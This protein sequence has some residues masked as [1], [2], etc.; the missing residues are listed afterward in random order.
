MVK[1]LQKNPLSPFTDWE[2]VACHSSQI[3]SCQHK[4]SRLQVHQRAANSW[5][6]NYT[7][8]LTWSQTSPPALPTGVITWSKSVT[9]AH[10]AVTEGSRDTS[11]PPKNL[12]ASYGPLRCLLHGQQCH[13]FLFCGEIIR[14]WTNT[15]SCCCSP[16]QLFY[17]GP[18]CNDK[19]GHDVKPLVS[20]GW[21]GFKQFIQFMW[22]KQPNSFFTS[23]SQVLHPLPSTKHNTFPF[24]C[25]IVF[26]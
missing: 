17:Q 7:C 2:Q 19:C 13:R 23:S 3:L 21:S 26:K 12:F 20:L 14:I 16:T 10:W 25:S 18:R 6:Q 5:C 4:D 22:L 1:T 8:V 9:F 15:I 11:C 24:L